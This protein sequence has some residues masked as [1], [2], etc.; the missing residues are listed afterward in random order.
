MK[1]SYLLKRILS[2]I[3]VLFIVSLLSFFFIHMIPGDPSMAL[4]GPNATPNEIENLKLEMGLDQP[5]PLQYATS[6]GRMLS[7]DMGNSILSGR[8]IF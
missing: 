3:P 8:P 5:L 1:I 4:L 2:A 6:L 7:G